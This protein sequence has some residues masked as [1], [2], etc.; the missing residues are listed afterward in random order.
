MY[1]L[2]D[3]T[4]PAGTT[5]EYP[6]LSAVTELAKSLG[7]A[8][9]NIKLT[10]LNAELI[11]S[12]KAPLTAAQAQALSPRIDVGISGDT[13]NTLLLALGG[14]GAFFLLTTLIKSR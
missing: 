14:I 10:D 4:A 7:I 2:G 11:R 1:T 8:Y 6:I 5:P 3:V 13:R 12:G 9:Q